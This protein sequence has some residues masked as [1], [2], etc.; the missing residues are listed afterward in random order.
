MDLEKKNYFSEDYYYDM[1][2][3]HINPINNL[4]AILRKKGGRMK[5]FWWPMHVASIDLNLFYFCHIYKN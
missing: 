1:A 5:E 3:E 2:L 4:V